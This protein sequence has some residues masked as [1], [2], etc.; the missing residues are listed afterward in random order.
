MAW[1][2]EMCVL[3]VKTIMLE[4]EKKKTQKINTQK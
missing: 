1:K 3:R 4:E 2:N